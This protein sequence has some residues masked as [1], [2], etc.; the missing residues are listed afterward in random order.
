MRI[1]AYQNYL[2]TE[3]QSA[4]PVQLIQLLYRGSIESIVAAR[5]HL[6]S[7]DIRARSR[8]ISKAMAIVTHLSMVLDH[9]KGG[10]MSQGLAELY[11]YT[12]TLLIQANNDQTDP[13]L[14]EAERL[15]STISEG[16]VG[17]IADEHMPANLTSDRASYSL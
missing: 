3:I 6:R 9:E 13:P 4:S 10:G 12:V 14:A 7:G 5:K 1:K 15:L 2:E 16:W 17:A 11:A 8:A